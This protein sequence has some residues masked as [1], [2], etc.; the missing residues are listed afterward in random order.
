MGQLVLSLYRKTKEKKNQE[1]NEK[2]PFL[3]DI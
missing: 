3:S 2:E 1:N